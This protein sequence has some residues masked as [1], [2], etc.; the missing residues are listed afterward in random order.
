M[1]AVSTTQCEGDQFRCDVSEIMLSIV[2]VTIAPDMPQRISDSMYGIL[3]SLRMRVG[4]DDMPEAWTL[5]NCLINYNIR[6]VIGLIRPLEL[7]QIMK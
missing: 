3:H 1:E 7:D 4:Y 2:I 6:I 5:I